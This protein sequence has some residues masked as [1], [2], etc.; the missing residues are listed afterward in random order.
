MVRNASTAAFARAAAVHP[1]FPFFVAAMDAKDAEI[2]RLKAQV[3]LKDREIARLVKEN[4][5]KDAELRWALYLR[6]ERE[7]AAMRA[8]TR[9]CAL[10]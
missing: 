1:D 5:L 9:P 3:A 2:A 10:S 6:W 7:R 4:E 8:S